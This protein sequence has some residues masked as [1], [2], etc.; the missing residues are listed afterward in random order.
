M[1]DFDLVYDDD[2]A[3]TTPP[4]RSYSEGEF[5]KNLATLEDNWLC[6]DPNDAKI[7]E[8]LAKKYQ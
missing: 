8:V 2:R 5:Y 6:M 4:P 3:D 7:V 1:D